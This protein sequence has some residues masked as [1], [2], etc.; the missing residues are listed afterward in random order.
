MVDAAVVDSLVYDYGLAHGEDDAHKTRK[1]WQ[2]PGRASG[3]DDERPHP[4]PILAEPA[5]PHCPRPGGRDPSYEYGKRTV[6]SA[7]QSPKGNV[8][9]CHFCVHRLERGE[10]PACV[11]TCMSKA[12]MCGDLND[13]D[14]EV[15]KVLALRRHFRLK[16]ELGT[17]PSV[18][19]LYEDQ[20]VT[21]VRN[22][23]KV[24]FWFLVGLGLAVGAT[25]MYQ[26]LFLGMRATNLSQMVPWGV[27]V[28]RWLPQVARRVAEQDPDGLFSRLAWMAVAFLASELE[29]LAAVD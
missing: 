17:N 26:R 1:I 12:R 15:R 14:S 29:S 3:S 24:L 11:Q 4:V 8:R 27:W 23:G 7:G 18:Y 6:R 20:E 22:T 9:R 16:E 2:S 5:Y 21:P 25:A 19:Y 13:P 28:A 10:Q